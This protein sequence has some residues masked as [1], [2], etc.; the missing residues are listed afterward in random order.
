MIC[1]FCL[2]EK[3]DQRSI[4]HIVPESLGGGDWAILPREI[5]CDS[6]NHYFGSKIESKVLQDYPFNLLRLFSGV[7]TK[8]KK[9]A[10]LNHSMGTLRASPYE[11]VIGIDPISSEM[12]DLILSGKKTK[13][14]VSAETRFPLLMC[15]FLLKIAIEYKACES[16]LDALNYKYSDARRFSR[17]PR[18]GDKWWFMYHHKSELYGQLGQ[19]TKVEI[20]DV[21]GAEI[22]W[23][24]IL[25]SHFFVP[26]DPRIAYEVDSELREP[27]YRYFLV[28]QSNSRN[29]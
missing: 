5:V 11:R 24:T 1:I 17:N 9:W 19:E 26:L 29:T 18:I 12:E 22:A 6:C 21:E 4:E 2:Y 23:I 25:G 16:V 27:E 10:T 8:K 3:D 20:V 13:F 7:V 15:R 14:H 28:Q